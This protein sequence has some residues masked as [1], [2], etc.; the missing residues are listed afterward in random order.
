MKRKSPPFS[1]IAFAISLLLSAGGYAQKE[2]SGPEPIGGIS[3]LAL[4]YYKINFT[5]EQRKLLHDRELEFI[6]FIDTAGNPGLEKINGV[7]DQSILDSLQNVTGRLP[8]FHPYTADGIPENAIYFMKIKFP[9]YE[10]VSVRTLYYNTLPFKR[11]RMEDFEYIHKSGNRFDILIGGVVNT[12]AGRMGDYLSSG[13]GMKMDLLFVGSGNM[14]AGLNMTMYGNK[15]LQ[16]YPINSKREQNSA[17]PIMLLGL[18]LNKALQKKERSEFNLQLELCY[19]IQN[20]TPRLDANDREWTQLRGFSPG[21]VCNYFFQLGNNKVDCSY[22]NPSI[23]THNINFHGAIRPVF[24]NLRE[25]T[26]I[27]AEL[28]ISYRLGNHFIDD[29]RLKP[30]KGNRQ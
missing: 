11:L 24:L 19:A 5:P 13:G 27:M 14:G 30:Q 21:I 1:I 10:E 25:A 3:K 15:L 2:A 12:F 16:N 17:P 22:G 29:F 18:S 4:E 28:G 7:S 26:G 9:G 23:A 8:R 6:Y 20:V